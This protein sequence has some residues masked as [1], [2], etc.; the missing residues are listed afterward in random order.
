MIRKTDRNHAEIINELRK[1]KSISVFSTHTIG[2]GFP[3]IVVGYQ[4]RNYL[5]EIK[6]ELKTK[7]QTKL[8][9]SEIKFH[10]SWHGQVSIVTNYKQIIKLINVQN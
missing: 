6:D 4:G 7:S 2:K 9:D 10:E 8:T 3:D 5:F 1:D